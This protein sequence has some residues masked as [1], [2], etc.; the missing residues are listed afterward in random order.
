MSFLI[1]SSGRTLWAQRHLFLFFFLSLF[2]IYNS[3]WYSGAVIVGYWTGCRHKLLYRLKNNRVQQE[4]QSFLGWATGDAAAALHTNCGIVALVE[5]DLRAGE[6][7][8]SISI[9]S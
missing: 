1:D 7:V 5:M 8:N 6:G 9:A 2:L 4:Q 3:T